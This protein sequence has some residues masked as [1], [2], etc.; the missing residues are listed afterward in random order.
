MSN[1]KCHAIPLTRHNA[2]HLRTRAA[3]SVNKASEFRIHSDF[4]L[5][6]FNAQQPNRLSSPAAFSNPLTDC[7]LSA[8]PPIPSLALHTC[9]HVDRTLEHTASF[10]LLSPLL[11]TAQR[12]YITCVTKA[13]I[14][15][16]KEV[17][18]NTR[19]HCPHHRHQAVN[20]VSCEH[21]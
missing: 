19:R 13:T 16:S 5:H 6:C 7:F 20:P 15:S 3:M 12:C 17:L 4:S 9:S 1:I 8:E 10:S 11:L 21:L 2:P 14:E 18:D